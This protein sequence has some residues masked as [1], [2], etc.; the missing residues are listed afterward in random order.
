ML[1]EEVSMSRARRSY[2]REFKI[3]AVRMVVDQGR[4][5]TE[6]ARNLGVS[7]SLVHRWK[8][9]LL[10]DGQVA[11]PGHGNLK[12]ADA[13]LQALRREIETTRQE[14]DILKKA[15]AFFAKDKR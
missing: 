3:E 2:D 14:R 5:V 12:P 10:E 1:L 9:Q 6:V 4:P 8:S 11:F 13:E 7:P 15:L